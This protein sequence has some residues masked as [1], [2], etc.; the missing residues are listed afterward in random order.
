MM[1]PEESPGPK[2]Y[3]APE[4]E[5][6]VSQCPQSGLAGGELFVGLIELFGFAGYSNL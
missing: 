1:K 4:D 2:N 3:T 6:S 5:S